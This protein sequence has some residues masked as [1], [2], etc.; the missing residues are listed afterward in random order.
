MVHSDQGTVSSDSG[1]CSK[2]HPAISARATR[3]RPVP[4]QPFL[5]ALNFHIIKIKPVKLEIIVKK[6]LDAD[7]LPYEIEQALEVLGESISLARRARGWTQA[8]LAAKIDASVNTVVSL[9]KGRP[10]VS[11]GQLA[12]ALWTLDRIDL[13]R[14][15]AAVDRD[16]IIQEAALGSI[17]RRVRS[18][19]G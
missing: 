1:G 9:E 10:S 2:P 18:R 15:V 4:A 7:L 11:L 13:L 14:E 5:S 16:T 19:R 17:P 12:K 8:D 3:K 6:R